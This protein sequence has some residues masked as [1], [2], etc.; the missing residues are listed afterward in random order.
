MGGNVGV[1]DGQQQVTHAGLPRV[2]VGVAVGV[3]PFFA[4]GQ[5]HQNHGGLGDK[6]LIVTGDG[7]GV[8]ELR[9]RD[10][11]NGVQLLIARRRGLY[12]GFQNSGLYRIGNRPVLVEPYRFSLME[13]A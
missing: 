11:Q 6:G 7:K 3:I 13:C 1:A 10:V 4:V 2:A 9:V 8:L 5:K 12:R